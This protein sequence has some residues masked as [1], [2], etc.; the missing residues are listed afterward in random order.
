MASAH[1]SFAAFDMSK[2][3]TIEG[4]VT[5]YKLENPHAHMQMLVTSVDG[6]AQ[7]NPT[8]WDVEGAAANI[9]R[10]QGWTAQTLKTGDKVKFVGHP[11]HSGDP[12]LSLF[13]VILPDGKRVYQDISRPTA[14]SKLP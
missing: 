3:I 2:N 9:M 14:D 10:R 4:T 12:G 5:A 11:L 7:P 1:H 13:Y 8:T 6:K